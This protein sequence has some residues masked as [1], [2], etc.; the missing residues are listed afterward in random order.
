MKLYEVNSRSKVKL[1]EQCGTPPASIEVKVG[2]EFTF[3]HVDGMY[4]YCKDNDGNIVH[5][6]AWAEVEV[7][8]KG[9][10]M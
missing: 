7:V 4:S 3:Y 8:D 5:L 9:D 6:Q 2:D 1:L 10:S